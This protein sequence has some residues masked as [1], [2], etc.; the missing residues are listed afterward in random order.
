MPISR[1][2]FIQKNTFDKVYFLDLNLKKTNNVFQTLIQIEKCMEK[3]FA[4]QSITHIELSTIIDNKILIGP[5]QTF[6]SV[7]S[8]TTCNLLNNNDELTQLS[9]ILRFEKLSVIKKDELFDTMLLEEYTLNYLHDKECL[10]NTTL[11][12]IHNEEFDLNDPLSVVKL[13]KYGIC[14]DENE[15]IYYRELFNKE[16]EI[17]I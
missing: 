16:K 4:L 3:T 13:K 12:N 11:P 2:F 5:I 6:E 7:F 9:K 1:L 8:T 17:L 10:S 14:F 15:L